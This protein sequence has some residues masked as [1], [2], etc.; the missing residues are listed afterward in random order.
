MEAELRE[1]LSLKLSQTS[2]NIGVLTCPDQQRSLLNT[3]ILS[4]LCSLCISL[5]HTLSVTH[6]VQTL[7][8]WWRYQ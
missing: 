7:T 5:A 8:E 1:S 6:V 2:Y 4:L 3:I